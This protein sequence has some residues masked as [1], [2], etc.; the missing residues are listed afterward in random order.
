MRVCLA[1]EEGEAGRRRAQAEGLQARHP[2]AGCSAGGG[3]VTWRPIFPPPPL[4]GCRDGR[5]GSRAGVPD[6]PCRGGGGGGQPNT[7][8]SK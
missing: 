4:L 6:L 3:G 1:S 5:G 2:K 8:G 7:Y